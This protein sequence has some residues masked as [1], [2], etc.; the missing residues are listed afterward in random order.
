MIR[1][2]AQRLAWS[3]LVLWIVVTGSFALGFILPADPARLI[4]GPHASQEVLDRVRADKHLDDPMIVQYGAYMWGVA[5]G[6]LGR[7][8]I[9]EEPVT[10]SLRRT[11]PWTALIALGA[12][13]FQAVVGVPLGLLAAL[14]RGTVIDYG[15]MAIALA[16]FSAPTFVI[17]L[18]LM[19][20]LGFHAGL[21]PIGGAGDGL[22]PALRSAALP[23]LTLGIA[24]SAYYVQLMRGEYLDVAKRDFMRTASAKGLRDGQ[25]VL[26]HGL[27]NAL[28]PVVTFFG[29][30]FG[31]LLGGAVVT[32]TIFAWPGVGKLAV[33][34]I[35]NQDIPVMLGTVLFASACVV[36]ANLVVDILYAWLDPRIRLS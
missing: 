30:D 31:A 18:S 3:V 27:P 8:Y 33:D 9:T 35:L 32:E 34:S 2:V 13:L 24:G 4:A 19:V 14:K 12:S 26:R 15:L 21:F 1:F 10:S 28:L 36:L 5:R 22:I 25:V 11:I 7:S 23:S 29:L 6:D 17:G 16:G 20:Y